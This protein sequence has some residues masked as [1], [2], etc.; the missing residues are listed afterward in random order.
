MIRSRVRLKHSAASPAR[1]G[2]CP[3][4]PLR[5]GGQAGIADYVN[6]AADGIERWAN[7]LNHQDLDQ[8]MRSV[9]NFARRQPALFL[10]IAFGAGVMAARFLKSSETNSRYESDYR[11]RYGQ[12]STSMPDYGST[13]GGGRST[14]GMGS[15]TGGALGSSS[16]TGPTGLGTSDRGAAQFGTTAGDIP[17]TSSD[18]RSSGEVL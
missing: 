11:S 13:G 15:S 1:F 2:G 6:K 4:Q 3:S 10:G 17:R 12:G 9:Q 14:A 5:D 8:A 18:P 16:G 7:N